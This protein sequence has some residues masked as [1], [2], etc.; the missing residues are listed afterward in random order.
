MK[1]KEGEHPYGDTGQLICL[2]IFAAVWVA[3]SFFLHLSTFLAAY[4][5]LFVRLII[6]GMM[7]A[8]AI[9]LAQSGHRVTGHERRPEGVVATG[10]F[11]Y[12]RH[13]LYLASIL[14]YLGMAVSTLSLLSIGVFAGVFVF[15]DRIARYEEHL[16][17]AKFGDDYRQYMK[18]TGKWVPKLTK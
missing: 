15:Y 14:A 18:M 8:A 5:P 17:E 3:D 4:V 2:G 9:Y 16:L 10:A 7:L 12:V 11:R 1:Q 6:L 13:P